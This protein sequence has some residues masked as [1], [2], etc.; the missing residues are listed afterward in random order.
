MLGRSLSISWSHLDS[1]EGNSLRGFDLIVRAVGVATDQMKQYEET[2]E[3]LVIGP[4]GK[5][6]FQWN[7]RDRALLVAGGVGIA[8]LLPLAQALR[9]SAITTQAFLGARTER[10]FPP[11][12][13]EDLESLGV[14]IHLSTEDGSV[15]QQGLVTDLL[16]GA[17]TFGQN[18]EVCACGP[19][20]MLQALCRL[21]EEKAISI[22]VSLES[23]TA[24][25]IGACLGC[26]I[27]PA[28]KDP[29]HLLKVC[30]D[31]PVFQ[32]KELKWP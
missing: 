24:C 5:R 27:L 10:E 8:P 13:R 31:G 6:G 26:A 2:K 20:A 21:C 25:G 18:A 14:E 1:S 12:A 15:G 9:C 32:G 16:D 7:G 4:L 30:V 11:G 28:S 19:A 23:M 17:L 29:N 3:L 22:Q